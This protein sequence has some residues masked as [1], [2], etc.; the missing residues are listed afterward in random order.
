MYFLD[1]IKL[2]IA[3]AINKALGENI[4]QASDLIIPPN[5][6]LGDFSLTCF[7]LAKKIGKPAAEIANDLVGKLSG[8]KDLSGCQS[9]GPYLNLTINNFL[10]ISGT[11]SRIADLA[12]EYGHNNIGKLSRAMVEFSNVNTHKEYHIGHLRNLSFGQAVVRILSANGYDAIPVSY[13]NDFGIHVAKTLWCLQNFY[14]DE[15]LPEN[16]GY[17]LGKVYARSN[18]EIE[19]DVLAK[20]LISF[21]MR[22]IESRQGE[23]YELWQKTRQWSIEQFAKIYQELGVTFTHIFYE[24]EYI[25][26][27]RE[28]VADLYAKR[29]LIKSQGAVIAD[30]E[31]F[32]LGVL[33]F[34]RT[35]GTA[36]YPV[37]D[38]PLAQ[39]KFKKYKLDKSIYVVDIRQSQYFKQLFKVLELLGYDKEM[40]HLTYDFVKLP[41]GMMSSRTGNVITYD[42]LKDMLLAKAIT[43][44]TERH[45]DWSKK[46][47]EEVAQKLTN[48]AIKFEMIKVGADKAITFDISQALHFEGYTAGYLQYTY[49]RIRSISRKAISND[50]LL[51]SK[52]KESKEVSYKLLIED[53]EHQIV[54]QLARYP[55]IIVKAGE[56][57]DPAEIAK[58]IFDL[59]L[60]FNDY[61][62][63]V[64][65]LKAEVEIA[66][67]RLALI[68]S[69]AQVIENG[70]GLLGVEVVEEM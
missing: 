69:V 17:F 68:S 38:L 57:Y 39:E 51:I 49:A 61:Y 70:L 50:Q 34:L 15:K 40:K 26:R 45:A 23:E 11:L 31:K 60:I 32:D 59:A 21:M 1:K 10:L 24:S 8:N 13:I 7:G 9:V 4:V 47:I 36:L 62:H 48:G 20:E 14:K 16:K 30:L 53:K 64:P 12:K 25:D 52:Q 2:D 58:Y 41:D 67:A 33:M 43:E 28:I 37:A 22:K 55:E 27:G 54:L 63:S 46:K 35:D 66:T 56:A 6:S 42:E 65:V 18:A 29:F 3:V 19:K 44:T 5:R